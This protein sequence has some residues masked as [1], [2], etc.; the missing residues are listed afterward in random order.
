MLSAAVFLA[1]HVAF[2]HRVVDAAPSSASICVR[3]TAATVC[4]SDVHTWEGKRNEPAP[5]V[6]GHEGVGV[7]ESAGASGIPPGTRVSWGVCVPACGPSGAGECASCAVGL[8]QK[9]AAGLF[10][11]GHSRWEGEDASRA[12]SGSFASHIY[13]RPG[14]DV[15]PLVGTLAALPDS[16]VCPANCA[17]ATMVAALERG[18]QVLGRRPCSVLLQGAGL[19]GLYGAALACEA[20]SGDGAMPLAVAV[21]D[22]ADGRL[23]LAREFGATLALNVAG[24]G[25]GEVKDALLGH[26][27][28]RWTAARG[29]AGDKHACPT[30]FDLV[31]EVCG[32]PSVL[33]TGLAMLRPGGVYVLVGCVHPASSLAGLTAEALI[34]GCAALVGVHNYG[35]HHL[36]AGLDF[37]AR[38][39]L[40]DGE[41]AE[42]G[43]AGSALTCPL[44]FAKLVSPPVPLSRLGDAFAQAKGGA[45][46]RV[47]VVP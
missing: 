37:L 5:L 45:F 18:T 30:G 39:Y 22:A 36:R 23:Q 34:R 6:L 19:L 21:T 24:L 17:L 26:L 29:P 27:R 10:K 13:L 2:E 41:E 1:P 4:G 40:P 38:H 35:P 28:D 11:Y 46:P 25:D 7:V 43:R 44:P 3:M 31:I 12:L 8:S 20:C 15:V 47:L 9:C 32:S 42:A 33:P 16:V 14:S